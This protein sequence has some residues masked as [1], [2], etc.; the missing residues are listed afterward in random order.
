MATSPARR[1][2][3]AERGEGILLAALR[4]GEEWVTE[5]VLCYAAASDAAYLI[6]LSLNLVLG[7]L[8]KY[9]E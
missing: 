7:R 2:V 3:R 4:Q 8:G 1:D 9:Q 6:R 5:C